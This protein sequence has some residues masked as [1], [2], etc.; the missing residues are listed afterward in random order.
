[1]FDAVSTI[2][3]PDF[4]A[5]YCYAWCRIA[6]AELKKLKKLSPTTNS[7]SARHVRPSLNSVSRV[8]V[9]RGPSKTRVAETEPMSRRC[10]VSVRCMVGF[11]KL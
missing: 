6:S 7:E 3:V 11:E 10:L 5:S 8:V 4:M 1:M 2:D 9:Y